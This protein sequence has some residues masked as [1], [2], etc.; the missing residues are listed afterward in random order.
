MSETRTGWWQEHRAGLVILGG[1][2]FGLVMFWPQITAR[3]HDIVYVEC[4][5]PHSHIVSVSSS[6]IDAEGWG[7]IFRGQATAPSWALVDRPLGSGDSR[8]K[9]LPIQHQHTP[10]VSDDCGL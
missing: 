7:K 4:T 3:F 8:F 10:A 1:I 6:Q 5:M 9:G 2:V